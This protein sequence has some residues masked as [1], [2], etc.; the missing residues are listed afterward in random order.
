MVQKLPTWYTMVHSNS[1]TWTHNSEL[2]LVK[3]DQYWDAENVNLQTIN[4]KIMNDENTIFNSFTN[5]SIDSCGCGTP[6]WM[7]KFQSMENVDYIQL[8]FSS[9]TF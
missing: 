2:I 7:E 1:E 5:G 9:S 4:Y 8:H 3:N 6:E